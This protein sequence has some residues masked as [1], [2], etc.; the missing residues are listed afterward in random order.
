MYLFFFRL[1]VL[2]AKKKTQKRTTGIIK[3]NNVQ[4]NGFKKKT[5]CTPTMN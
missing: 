1:N 2:E 3:K 5:G 4:L